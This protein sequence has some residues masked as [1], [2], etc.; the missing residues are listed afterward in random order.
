MAGPRAQA[1]ARPSHGGSLAARL[2]PWRN[3]WALPPGLA[4]FFSAGAHREYNPVLGSPIHLSISGRAG[5]PNFVRN[6]APIARFRIHGCRVPSDVV[7]PQ[8]PPLPIPE[9]CAQKNR[10]DFVREMI[11]FSR[12]Q[13]SHDDRASSVCLSVPAGVGALYR[14]VNAGDWM[15]PAKKCD[16]CATTSL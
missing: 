15:P 12:A 9:N 13:H 10:P 8:G 14:G 2:R 3:Q 4:P 11:L 6:N 7:L 16:P 1:P 5:G